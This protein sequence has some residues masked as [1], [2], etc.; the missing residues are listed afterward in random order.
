MYENVGKCDFC[1]NG[2]EGFVFGD[3]D[4]CILCH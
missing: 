1:E 4:P 2:K 3:F